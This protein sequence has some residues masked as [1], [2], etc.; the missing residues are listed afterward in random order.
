[1]CAQQIGAVFPQCVPFFP[2]CSSLLSWWCGMH[3]RVYHPLKK[4]DDS[5]L[6]ALKS[7]VEDTLK[8]IDPL[9]PL[10]YRQSFED[11]LSSSKYND[12]DKKKMRLRFDQWLNTMVL[13]KRD[14]TLNSF[15][16]SECYLENKCPRVI[17]GRALG[18]KVVTGF[19]MH[20]IENEVMHRA[21][22]KH[23]VKGMDSVSVVSRVKRLIT[24][25]GVY[26]ETDYTNF[27][28]SFDLEIFSRVEIPLWKHM[29]RNNKELLPFILGAYYKP[30]AWPI[31]PESVFT[32]N[33]A[34]NV[35]V[36]RNRYHGEP[37]ISCCYGHG[38]RMSGDT[39]T[40]LANG[41]TNLM[42]FK[43]LAQL[44]G[45]IWDGIVE[46]DDGLFWV[47][48]QAIG[49]DDYSKLGFTIKMEY[50]SNPHELDFCGYRVDMNSDFAIMR[51][52]CVVDAGWLS[53]RGGALLRSPSVKR[54]R[55]KARLLSVLF[56]GRGHPVFQEWAYRQLILMRDVQP[57]FGP[58]T[59]WTRRLLSE[60]CVDDWENWYCAVPHSM[61]VLFE[62]I[63]D[64][65][66]ES[67][68]RM[69]EACVC[70]R[71]DLCEM[72]WHSSGVDHMAADN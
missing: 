36:F 66:V 48:R 17:N 63:Y 71:F 34:T 3:K 32:E 24:E 37:T 40:S 57:D 56:R 4:R 38:S 49:P 28:G 26:L 44:K 58:S 55:Y 39:W 62:Q 18:C 33:E 43:T 11:Y 6:N 72:H 15:V 52:K 1:M 46:G 69:E 22:S 67:Q 53:V 16:K 9:P 12:R 60:M 13:D 5:Y 20:A 7:V 35:H 8:A 2:N 10:N 30:K 42:L 25:G 23:F 31:T 61:R 59:W 47:S 50:V 65:S 68:L 70:G 41:F 27:E 54:S 14:Y 19:I 45:V 51:H 29:L 21:L 64:V